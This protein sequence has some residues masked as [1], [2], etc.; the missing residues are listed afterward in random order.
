MGEPSPAR[1]W[2]EAS[3][4][5]T[6]PPGRQAV[7]IAALAIGL[8]LLGV[9]LWLLTVA[10]DLY[11]SGDGADVWTL[12]LASAVVFLGGLLALRLLGRRSKISP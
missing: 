11:L 7:V 3:E 8:L 9:Q 5:G 4:E 2:A 10:L 1:G 12:A 6:P